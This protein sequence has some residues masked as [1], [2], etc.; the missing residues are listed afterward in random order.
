MKHLFWFKHNVSKLR[1][2]A[3]KLA[4]VS[5]LANLKHP[6][7]KPNLLKFL[8]RLSGTILMPTSAV[9][10]GRFVEL[11]FRA[12]RNFFPCHLPKTV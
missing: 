2:Y 6:T 3:P 1:Y 12:N 5:S 10:M 7:V 11:K 4:F 9:R 8:F